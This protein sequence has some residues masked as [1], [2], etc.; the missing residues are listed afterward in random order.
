MKVRFRYDIG[1]GDVDTD[2][3]VPKGATPPKGWHKDVEDTMFEGVL[4]MRP[5]DDDSDVINNLNE[6]L[7]AMK[8]KAKPA[9]NKKMVQ[10]FKKKK[11]KGK[12]YR[13]FCEFLAAL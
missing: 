12:K 11:S 10:S 7:A 5:H 13:N 1:N 3:D 2:V 4:V 6:F 9:Q 8:L